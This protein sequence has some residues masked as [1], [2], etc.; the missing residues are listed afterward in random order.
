MT[1]LLIFF[2]AYLGFVFFPTKKSLI[3]LTGVGCLLLSRVLSI[4]MALGEVHWNVIGLFLG[5]LILAELFLLSRMPAFLAEWL[6]DHSKTV[7]MALM[8]VFILTSVISMFVENVAVVL[9][10]AP[11]V[12]ALC[13]KLRLSPTKPIILLAMFSNLQ[14]TATLIGDPP[15]MILGSYM[16][17]SFD[18]FFF[19]LGKPSIFFVTQV[20]A[21]CSLIFTFWLLRKHREPIKIMNVEK[22]KSWIPSMLL[23]CLI[24]FLAFGSQLDPDSS[25]LAGSSAMFLGVLGLIWQQSGPKWRKTA[26]MLQTLDWDTTLFL[27]SLF[28]LVGAIRIEGWMD[29]LAHWTVENVPNK[30]GVIYFFIISLS[31]VISAFVDNVPYLIAMIPVVQQIA[32][33]TGF[34]LPLLVF[35]LLVGSCLGGNVTPIG[36]S[37]NIVAMGFLQ[38]NGRW[39]SFLSYMRIGLLFTLFAVLP[40]SIMLWLIWA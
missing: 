24:G 13:E 39:F 7:R 19:Y 8:N 30:L 2:L 25:W 11:I 9:L 18:D 3:S 34:S 35:G 38:K 16:K 22:I 36:A 26:E 1:S 23:L 29:F 4:P 12:L 17:M 14:G 28:I 37:A 15:S 31:L 40:A 21:I 10:I 32:D 6:V 20:G 5:T 33:A 27:A